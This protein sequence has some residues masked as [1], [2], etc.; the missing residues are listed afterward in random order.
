[1]RAPLL[2][3]AVWLLLL[4]GAWWAARS[5]ADNQGVVAARAAER[6]EFAQIPLEEFLRDRAN[7]F[8]GAVVDLRGRAVAGAEVQV[9]TVEALS[10][11]AAAVPPGGWPEPQP[12]RGARADAAGRYELRQLSYGSKMALARQAGHAAAALTEISFADG[13]GA[14]DVDATLEPAPDWTLRLLEAD[15]RPARGERVRFLPRCFGLPALEAGADAEGRVQVPEAVRSASGAPRLLVGDPPLLVVLRREQQEVT[16]AARA[17]LSLELENAEDGPLHLE[18][19]PDGAR[20]C[21]WSTH[22]ETVVNGRAAAGVLFRGGYELIARQGQS[23]AR[24]RFQHD[25]TPLRL[26]LGAPES[27]SVAVA[28]AEGAPLA[29]R[30]YWQSVPFAPADPFALDPLAWTEAADPTRRSADAD[31]AGVARL[32]DLPGVAGWLLVEAHGCAPWS[33]AV[34]AGTAEL[35]V[36]P[37]PALEVSIRTDRAYLPVQVEIPGAPP[38]AGRSDAAGEVFVAAAPG[39]LIARCGFALKGRSYPK[40]YWVGRASEPLRLGLLD[41]RGRPRGCVYGFVLDHAGQPVEKAEVFVQGSDGRPDRAETDAHGF[42]RFV[43]LH[44]GGYVAFARRPQQPDEMWRLEG[45][46]L[47]GVEG[48]DEGEARL[49]L[50]LW[51]GALEVRFGAG[52]PRPAQLEFLDASGE[53]VW[54]ATPDAHGVARVRNV[55]PGPYRVYGIAQAQ[56]DPLLLGSLDVPAGSEQ[57][58]VLEVAQ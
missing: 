9:F 28:S 41:D 19:L 44:A 38:L 26:R 24:A 53:R 18:F 22:A 42:Y 51:P 3:A 33:Q 16:L 31:A 21:G 35:S 48:E 2:M 12:E 32:D 25:G 4:A 8:S 50:R 20:R 7:V 55:A 29:A 34:A 47:A 39:P 49:D 30:V 1:M 43:G 37:A 52:T 5:S 6:A 23:V 46:E 58:V 10:A 45:V 36:H 27:L 15:A 14:R 54:S 56:A 13:Y 57:P 40:G 11:A 17:P